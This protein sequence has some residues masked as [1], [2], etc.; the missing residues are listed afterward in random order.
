[1]PLMWNLS[2]KY[3]QES[4][5]SLVSLPNDTSALSSKPLG[6]EDASVDKWLGLEQRLPE[7]KYQLSRVTVCDPGKNAQ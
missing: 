6:N 7:W 4:P 5:I 2:V 3:V 1:M